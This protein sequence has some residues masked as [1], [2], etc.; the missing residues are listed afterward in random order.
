MRVASRRPAFWRMRLLHDPA[1]SFR[2]TNVLPGGGVGDR[3]PRKSFE[4]HTPQ[5]FAPEPAR[6]RLACERIGQRCTP[7]RD[8][9]KWCQPCDPLVKPGDA[10][11]KQIL[12]KSRVAPPAHD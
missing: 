2:Q 8:T 6:A 4:Y 7:V 1:Q 10:R 9:H 3:P 12:V 11:L 5:R